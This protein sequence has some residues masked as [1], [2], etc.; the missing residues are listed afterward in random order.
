MFRAAIFSLL[1]VSSIVS[2]QLRSDQLTLNCQFVP[3]IEAGFLRY[4]VHYSQRDAELEKHV[5]E[6]YLKKIDPT[7][8]YL[9]KTEAEKVRSELKNVFEK[10]KKKDCAF[11][12]DIQSITLAQAQKR[13]DFAK[14]FLGKD[15]KFDPKTEFS[16]DPEH[17][18]FA[19]NQDE[20][21]EFVKKYIHFQISNYLATDIKIDEAKQKV[22]K[23]YERMQKRL[24]EETQDQLIAD[25]LDTFARSLD[26]H[27]SFFSRDVLDDFNINMSLSLEGIGAT[28]SSEVG[29]TKVEALVPGGA[30]A[31]DGQ[32]QVQDKII[33]V[34]QGEE[35]KVDKKAES[36]EKTDSEKS[37]AGNEEKGFENVIDMDI[38]DVVK[39]IRGT[40]GTKVRLMVLR[41]VGDQKHKMTITI[42]RDKVSL[43]D[44]AASITYMDKKN[45]AGKNVKVGL[46]NFPAFYS[47]SHRGGRSSAADLKKIVKEARK[48]N[49]DGLVLDLSTNGGGSLED[50][51]KVAGLFFKT[52]NVVKQSSKDN[53]KSQQILADTDAEVD[54][55]GPM[56]ILT[57]RIS[58]SASEI[59]SGTLQDYKRALIVG[60]DHTF[61]KGSVQTVLPLPGSLGALK[62]TVGMFFVPGGNST[63]HRGVDADVVLPSALSIDDLGEKYLDYS[64]PPKKIAAFLSPEAYVKEGSSA[65]KEI[66]TEWLPVLREK[67]KQ[68]VSV[69]GEFKKIE[70]DLKK[71]KERGK[72]IRVAEILKETK[73]KEKIEKKTKTL[74]YGS[75]AD[76]EKE[77][78]KRPEI[79]EAS[80]V[81]LDLIQI[82]SD[83]NLSTK[84][85]AG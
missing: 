83:K 84:K 69:N 28:L 41:G 76:K 23:N 2:A 35:K 17:R 72:L 27:S 18:E 38:K 44:E 19:K 22:I 81:L 80:S 57:S 14:K 34:A 49:V 42:T 56:V 36:K 54:W 78:L 58:A 25:Y 29:F 31:R 45:S 68:R 30:A 75:K 71:S 5:I 61:G 59:V 10:T 16:Y 85:S 6:Q 9:T 11:L 15:Y 13:V 77:Y 62:V 67:S 43:E 40:K 20:L 8:S 3:D 33:A 65:W 4:H 47:D 52:G 48:K 66:Q 74:R 21:D 26:P 73:E 50:A 60:G 70:E 1:F 63:Q 82:E 24:G 32:L 46:I 64:L 39:K 7:K 55:A 53:E 79:Q 51:V 37:L 12:T